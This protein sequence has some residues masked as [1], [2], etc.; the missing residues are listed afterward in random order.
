MLHMALKL[1]RQFIKWIVR[2]S[3]FADGKLRRML[4]V[5]RA[6]PCLD[7]RCMAVTIRAV[8][9]SLALEVTST[10]LTTP[11]AAQ[12]TDVGEID[13]LTAHRVL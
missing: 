10:S 7:R 4:L 11:T 9:A 8:A 5:L 2:T 12:T 1:Q 6:E 3:N 13:L